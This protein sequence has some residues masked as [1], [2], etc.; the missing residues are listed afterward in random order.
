MRGFHL[1]ATLGLVLAASGCL[2]AG[3]EGEVSFADAS[4]VSASITA[5]MLTVGDFLRD[6][7]PDLVVGNDGGDFALLLGRG[8]GS[9][10]ELGRAV[11]N[12]LRTLIAADFNGDS[13]TDVA[14]FTRTIDVY[15]GDSTGS[16]LEGLTVDFDTVAAQP[17]D[18]NRDR[19]VDLAA[20]GGGSLTTQG[21]A[22]GLFFSPSSP[23]TRSTVAVNLPR[24]VT[25]ADFNGDGLFEMAVGDSSQSMRRVVILRANSGGTWTQGESY[26]LGAGEIRA[27]V[28]GD[29]AGD[30]ALDLAVTGAAGKVELLV[31]RGDAT[32]TVGESYP[33]DPDGGTAI[34]LLAVD[35]NRGGL[36]DLVVLSRAANGQ[37]TLT[38][39]PRHPDTGFLAPQVL[40]RSEVGQAHI[41]SVAV[42]DANSDGRPDIALAGGSRIAL[43]LNE[44]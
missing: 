4:E 14:L 13:H 26:T 35:I 1:G 20:V 12:P 19:T 18:W 40:G 38:I 43:F 21:L 17:V 15:Y 31:G 28:V 2:E 44:R 29:F 42:F 32:F 16:I 22:A 3:Q 5:N 30:R 11:S 10:V 6:G 34:Q 25:V 41:A 37:G 36:A 8:N 7:A 24:A 9:F 23:P 33:S 39:L 27:M